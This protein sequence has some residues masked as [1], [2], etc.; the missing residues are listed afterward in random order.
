MT[1]VSVIIPT[2]NRA[3]LLKTAIRSVCEQTYSDWEAIIIDD[4]SSDQTSEIVHAFQDD[5]IKYL[6]NHGK[7]GPS[8]SRNLG[9]SAAIG[10]YIAFLDDD[11]EWLPCKLEKQLAILDKSPASVCGIYSNRI[12]IDKHSGNTISAHLN[13][14]TL[15]GNLLYQLM[16]KNPI[17]TPTLVVR[18]S[19]LDE[20]GCFDEN[21]SYMED[22]DLWIRLA[23]RWDFEYIDEALVKVF[24]HG[25][26]HLSRDLL[27]QTQGRA[28]LL[29]R[30]QDL[31]SK[32][33]K[34][35]A[36]LHVCQGAQYCQLG[37]MKQGRSNLFKGIT[38]Y[39]GYWLAYLHFFA[40]LLGA[41]I[42]NR[43]RST[44]KTVSN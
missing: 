16:L 22:R 43:I 38:I 19:C 7:S 42:Y 3:E 24:M 21:M 23:L 1:K 8:T 10:N 14:D 18:K 17:A 13:A 4:H 36:G 11:D 27:G 2:H 35:W 29:N 15:R 31:L 9:I 28:I 33:R 30:Y 40:S 26:E 37:D 12:K 6:Q 34:K 5:R 25:N 44:F 39:P 32:N 41:N 20:V